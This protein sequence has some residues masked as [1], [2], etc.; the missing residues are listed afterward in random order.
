VSQ[1]WLTRDGEVASRQPRDNELSPRDTHDAGP[2]PAAVR[3]HVDGQRPDIGAL[4]ETAETDGVDP[5][6][7]DSTDGRLA[8]A[9]GFAGYRSVPIAAVRA[10]HP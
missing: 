5:Y 8:L 7:D 2:V 4:Y 10:M 3:R 9:V 1:K 6:V